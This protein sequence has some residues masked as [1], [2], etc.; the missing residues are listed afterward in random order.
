MSMTEH[1]SY[2]SRMGLAPAAEPARPPAPEH[3]SAVYVSASRYASRACCCP[4]K[5][6]VIVVLAAS[7]GR[8]A[9]T[10]LLFCGHHYRASRVALAAK[11]ALVM[12]LDGY[13]LAD[14][15]WPEPS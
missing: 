10:D 14:G 3:A 15:D 8:G 11:G 13:A 1:P 2:Q 5:P 12:D 4:A 6:A 7:G 9:P